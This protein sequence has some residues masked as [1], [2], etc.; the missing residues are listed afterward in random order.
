MLVLEFVSTV[1]ATRSGLLDTLSDVEDMTQWGRVHA[2]ELGISAGFTA[3]EDLWREVVELRQA[4][5]AL[6]APAGAA[7]PPRTA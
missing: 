7:G 6:L 5:R 4:V 1:R 2:A 3:T